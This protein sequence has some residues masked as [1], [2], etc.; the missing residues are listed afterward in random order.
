FLHALTYRLHGHTYFDPAAYRPEGEAE[1]QA[2]TDDPIERQ[3]DA[4]TAA[5]VAAAELDAIREAARAEMAASLDAAK[6][7]PWPEDAAAFADVQDLGS[8]AETPF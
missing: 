5:G 6:A 2:A 8:P 3:R 1:R 7:A 4:L